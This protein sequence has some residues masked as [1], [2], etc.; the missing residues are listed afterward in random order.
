[1]SKKLFHGNTTFKGSKIVKTHTPKHL[2][3][4]CLCLKRKMKKKKHMG[5]IATGLEKMSRAKNDSTQT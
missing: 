3:T 4:C 5:G 2:S 1:M